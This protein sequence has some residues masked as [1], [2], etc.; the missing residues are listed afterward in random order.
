M[1]FTIRIGV[2]T[3]ADPEGTTGPGHWWITGT[4]RPAL[5]PSSQRR[6][7]RRARHGGRRHRILR[8]LGSQTR[9]SAPPDLYRRS[10]APSAQQLDRAGH[11]WTGLSARARE[12]A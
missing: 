1:T 10:I 8:R 4:A 6:A 3:A 2:P 12:T 5:V 9:T 7:I 11:T